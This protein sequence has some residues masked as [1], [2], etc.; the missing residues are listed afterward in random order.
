[1]RE[2]ARRTECANKVRQ[3]SLAVINFESSRSRFPAGWTSEEDSIDENLPG[4]AWSAE[5]LPFIEQANLSDQID[6]REA[7]L[8]DVNLPFTTEVIET[9]LCP[10][11]PDPEILNFVT[12]IAEP[13]GNGSGN[14]NTNT[15]SLGDE[16]LLARTNYSGVFGNIDN[17]D[18]PFRGDGLFL[19]LIHI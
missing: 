2:A 7:I 16:L 17:N 18:D 12:E 11:D 4:W 15:S 14:R 1:M 13:V 9:Y 8:E 10:S 19:S 5:I 6:F 3:L